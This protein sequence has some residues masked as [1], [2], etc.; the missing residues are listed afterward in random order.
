MWAQHTIPRAS[1]CVLM[2]KKWPADSALVAN[3]STAKGHDPF[4]TL[5]QK[6]KTKKTQN[7][8]CQKGKAAAIDALFWQVT[9][10]LSQIVVNKTAH[11]SARHLTN[12]RLG[13][14]FGWCN[15]KLSLVQGKFTLIALGTVLW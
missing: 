1:S 9:C 12:W 14:S 5:T 13:F 8:S 4:S 6:K 11:Q 7:T 10:G 15:G 2:G 3:S